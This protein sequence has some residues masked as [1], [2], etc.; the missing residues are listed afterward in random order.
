MFDVVCRPDGGFPFDGTRR[1]SS[2]GVE[3]DLVIRKLFAQGERG[4]MILMFALMIPALAGMT[5]MA[6]DVGS[7]AS[8]RRDLQNAADSIALAAAQELPNES[9][10]VAAGQ[11]WATKNNIEISDLSVTPTGGTTAPKVSVSIGRNHN[12][13]FMKVL[14]VDSAG[15]NASAAAVKASFAGGSGIVPWAVTQATI[16][17]A[18]N[19]SMVLKYDSNGVAI[20]NFGVI[21]IDGSGSSSYEHDVTYGS[22]SYMCAES[23]EAC[24]VT[25]CPG[26]FPNVCAETAPGC[27]G[28][29]CTP[30]TGN[31]IGST[32][33]AIDYRLSRT[34]TS[35][36]EFDEVFSNQQADGTYQLVRDC[37]P[38]VEGGGYC[39]TLASICSRRVIIVPV[40]DT[41]GQGASF[42]P[43]VQRF[44]LLFLEGYAG[45]CSGNDCEIRGRFVRA[46]LTANALAGTYDPQASI[47]FVR[48]SE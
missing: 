47:N 45:T 26:E 13:T 15:V 36:D 9:A 21:R 30:E 46:E 1:S 20:G 38:W 44:A 2:M 4:Q 5:G 6:I 3:E 32:K 43:T 40:V 31:M 48:L 42:S 22:E 10:A 39:E 7:Y 37:N 18:G 29:E 41:F 35:C 8:D 24:S 33:R 27:D 17:A 16:D 19:D 28:P 14:G 23:L 34:S 25:V 11:A 12:F